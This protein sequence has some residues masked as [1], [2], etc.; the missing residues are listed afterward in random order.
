[1]NISLAAEPIGFIGALPVTNTLIMA[2]GVSALLTLLALVTR[3]QIALVPTPGVGHA[4]EAV[5]D[6]LLGFVDSVTHDRERSVRFLP[7]VATIFL[8]VIAS[9]WIELLPGLGT[10]GVVE[11]HGGESVIVP[12]IRSASADLNVTIAVA[13]FSVGVTQIVGMRALGAA[14][15]WKKFFNFSNPIFTFV[16]LLELVSE[17]S[18]IVSFSFRL[19]GNIFAGEVLLLV[20]SSLAPYIVPLPFLLLELFVGFIQALVFSMLT[21]VNLN[22]AV[23]RSEH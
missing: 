22:M 15:H 7:Y 18:K 19:F 12:F 8:F 14:G 3:R 2:I 6:G 1:M 17:S 20:V 21:L 11:E 9:N 10:I 4:V 16:G 13:L 23:A 5:I